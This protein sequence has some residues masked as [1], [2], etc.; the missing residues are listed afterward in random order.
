MEGYISNQYLLT[1]D[2]AREKAR[3][4]V[5]LRATVTADNLNIRQA[6]ALDLSLIHI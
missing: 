4:L 5:K 3:E 1:G 2:E 6:P